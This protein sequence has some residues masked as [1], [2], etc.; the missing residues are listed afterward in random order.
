MESGLSWVCVDDRLVHVSQF[1]A[2]PPRKRPAAECPECGC[3]LIL[4]LGSIRRHHA[5]HTPGA[6]CIATRPESALHIEVK[7]YIAAQLQNGSTRGLRVSSRCA[8]AGD[9]WCESTWEREWTGGWDEVAIES[10]T[11]QLSALRRPDILLLQRGKPVGAIE[12]LVTHA[13]SDEKAAALT[14]EGLPWIEV[15]ADRTLV[16]GAAAWT[17]ARPL[18]VA[19]QGTPTAPS[20]RA[21]RCDR[22]ERE[23]RAFL[24]REVRR[25]EAEVEEGRRSSRIICARV[26]DVYREGGT[27]DRIIYRCEERRVNGHFDSYALVADGRDIERVSSDDLHALVRTYEADLEARIAGIGGFTDS[28]MRWATGDVAEDLVSEGLYDRVG[29]DPTPLAT[30]YPRRWFY[31]RERQ[32]WFLPKEMRS[33]QW[34]RPEG[35]VFAS[36]PAWTATHR[37]VHERISDASVQTTVVLASRPTVHS[38][39]S[40]MGLTSQEGCIARLEANGRVLLLLTAA[41]PDEDVLR[42]EREL[43]DLGIDHL[44]LAHPL[45]W[46]AA[47]KNLAW[48]PAARDGYGRGIV[49]IDGLGVFR[50]EPFARACARGDRRFAPEKVRARHAERVS[51]LRDRSMR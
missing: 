15:R 34:D 31:A 21:W 30:R 20:A 2:V 22:H 39:G 5:A 27:R 29:A 6:D 1:A 48:A 40:A 32:K 28:P 7:L 25:R 9:E 23:Y 26:V 38:F 10:K 33:V 3:S 12:V 37:A 43:S 16:E 46:S 19:R 45:D 4:K 8:G 35:D 13:V 44:W 14:E 42:I 41:A 49:L 24:D 36:H 11:N 51:A 17:P 18:A 47:R 50:A